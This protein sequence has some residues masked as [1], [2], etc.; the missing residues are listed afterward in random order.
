MR[1]PTGP[2]ECEC[3]LCKRLFTGLEAFDRHRAGE[4]SRQCWEPS[5][6]GLHLGTDGLWSTT[7]R[8]VRL[9]ALER[10]R[11][12]HALRAALKRAQEGGAA[13]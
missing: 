8:N 10:T 1:S 3:A 11:R 5:A 9:D 2:H 12:G 4:A 7:F 6:I 13:A